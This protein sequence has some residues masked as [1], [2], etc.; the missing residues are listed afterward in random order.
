VASPTGFQSWDDYL[1]LN[2]DAEQR[3]LEA[4]VQEAEATQAQ[5]AQALQRAGRETTANQM[6]E[7]EGGLATSTLSTSGSY[8]DYVRL[9]LK[10]EGQYAAALNGGDSTSSAARRMRAGSSPVLSL[11]HI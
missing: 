1:Q 6:R 4:A 7:A 10:A 2:G 8:S 11:I 3:L 9:K 5:A